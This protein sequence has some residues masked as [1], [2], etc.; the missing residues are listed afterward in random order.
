[1]AVAF[2]ERLARFARHAAAF[3]TYEVALEL[4]AMRADLPVSE[5]RRAQ[6][7][8]GRGYTRS[9]RQAIY[10][11]VMSGHSRRAVA[12]VAGLS[13]ESVSRYCHEVEDERDDEQLDRLLEE[14][15]LEM[16]P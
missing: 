14:L 4:V 16:T 2:I 5:L 8:W 7:R 1:M 13:A 10:L 9:K 11:A 3:A 6:R 15:E 12:R